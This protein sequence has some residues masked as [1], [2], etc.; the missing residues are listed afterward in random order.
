MRT[1]E[2]FILDIQYGWDDRICKS[3]GLLFVVRNLA[4]SS[5][6]KLIIG[7]ELCDNDKEWQ[8]RKK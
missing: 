8:K 7:T 5:P 4:P 3:K 1:M 2:T 6:M